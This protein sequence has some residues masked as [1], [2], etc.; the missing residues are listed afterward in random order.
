MAVGVL[1]RQGQLVRLGADRGGD[2]SDGRSFAFCKLQMSLSKVS[3]WRL[4]SLESGAWAG[5][6]GWVI[7]GTPVMAR[8][9]ILQATDVTF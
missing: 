9:C 1:G 7:V 3:N 6:L 4:A 5:G 2:P 8:S